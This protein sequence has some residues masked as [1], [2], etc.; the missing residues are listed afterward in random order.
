MYIY[1][2]TNN[3]NNKIYIGKSTD[4]R[5]HKKISY[6]GSGLLIG[7]AIEKYGISNFTKE[8]I[9]ECLDNDELCEKEMYWILHYNSTDSSVGYNITP[10]G[11]GGDTLSNHPNADII[12][13]KISNTLKGR[14]FTEDH[15]KNLCINHHSILYNGSVYTKI[16]KS[17]KDKEKT[18]EHK[19]NISNSI[20]K[21]YDNGYKGSFHT[22]NP[23]KNNTYIW[24]YDT[25]TL[26]S[27]RIK[28]TE[29]L[30]DNYVKGRPPT[31]SKKM[32]KSQTGRCYKFYHNREKT[33]QKR[34]YNDQL[35]PDGWVEGKLVKQ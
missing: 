5:P 23:M 33:K 27:K 8:I 25:T 14:V 10:G 18:Q 30:P 3:I 1:K 9:D 35:P 17:L 15:K 16:S 2:I 19:D 4:S 11:T 7:R 34:I 28:S 26:K 22:N 13:E 29:S 12:R 6:Y 20:K 32:S 24:V 31:F 21:L